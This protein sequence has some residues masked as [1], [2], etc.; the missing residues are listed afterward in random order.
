MITF[1]N[2]IIYIVYFLLFGIFLAITYDILHYYLKRWNVKMLVGYIVQ[3]LYW[4]G[5]VAISCLYAFRV[6][7]GMISIYTFSFFFLGVL[8][9]Y[10]FLRNNL[11]KDLSRI[12]YGFGKIYKTIKNWLIELIYPRE[13]LFLLIK[14]S[15]AIWKKISKKKLENQEETLRKQNSI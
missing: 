14:I 5:L 15:K 8:T 2:Q 7:E 3:L 4:L 1:K 6:S 10:F 13:L 12:N 9:Y 11:Y